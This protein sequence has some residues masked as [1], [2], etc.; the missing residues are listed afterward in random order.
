MILGSILYFGA[1]IV[2]LLYFAVAGW[3]GA[4]TRWMVT[5]IVL[6][7]FWT[8]AVYLFVCN[9]R[10]HGF[11]EY[12]WGWALLFP[13]TFVAL[14]SYLGSLMWIRSKETN[15]QSGGSARG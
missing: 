6:Q 9:A 15:Q 12:Y 3:R 8:M 14:L 7:V 4:A 13:V 10:S 11:R 2:P 5:G 1:L